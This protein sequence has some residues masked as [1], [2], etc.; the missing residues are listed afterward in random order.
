MGSASAAQDDISWLTA[1]APPK[2]PNAAGWL[3]STVD[4]LSAFASMMAAGVGDVL[5]PE[6]VRLMTLDRMTAEERA[7]NRTGFWADAYAGAR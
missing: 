2:I 4:D 3:V 1:S 7:E 5:S 6:S